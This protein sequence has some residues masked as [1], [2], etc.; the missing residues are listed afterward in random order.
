MPFCAPYFL[1]VKRRLQPVHT[2]TDHRR[3]RMQKQRRSCQDTTV[4][5]EHT[6]PGVPGFWAG[7]A[8]SPFVLVAINLSLL[9]TPILASL[10]S[11]CMR[12]TNLC[13]AT[14]PQSRRF[15]RADFTIISVCPNLTPLS[16]CSLYYSQAR[17]NTPNSFWTQH[18]YNCYFLA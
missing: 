15:C 12:H 6:I 3:E 4:M 17:Q 14:W 10:A 7:A 16:P 2:D 11:L 18:Q 1:S 8:H 13:L 9:Q 5:N